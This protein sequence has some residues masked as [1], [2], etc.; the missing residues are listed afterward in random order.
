MVT[1]L[2]LVKSYINSKHG[3]AVADQFES[4]YE[5]RSEENIGEQNLNAL[6][7][8]KDTLRDIIK[9]NILSE[10]DVWELN[11]IIDKLDDYFVHL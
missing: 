10:D 2:D 5:D 7:Y 11:S 6:K 8:I 4:V 1:V 3:W 9:S